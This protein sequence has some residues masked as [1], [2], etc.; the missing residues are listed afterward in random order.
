M[1]IL[2]EINRETERLK[3]VLSKLFKSIAFLSFPIGFFMILVAE[4]AF[5]LI[6]Q[7]KWLSAVPYFRMLAL[8]GIV[9]PFI[10]VLNE[11]YI[12]KER[13]DFF[14]GLEIAKRIVLV[15]LIGLLISKGIMGLAASWVIYTYITLGASLFLSHSLIR[16]SGLHFLQDVYPYALAALACNALGYVSTRWIGNNLLFMAANFVIVGGSYLLLCRMFRLEM[17]REMEDRFSSRKHKEK[18]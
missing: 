12:A 13:A 9:S 4:A 3:R 7:E 5:A 2:S 10:F 17:I 18:S 15:L 6:W 14:L 11:L 8:A 16:Y 1:L